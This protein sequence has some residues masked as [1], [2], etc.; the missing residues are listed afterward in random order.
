MAKEQ[1]IKKLAVSFSGGRTS[2][3]MTKRIVEEWSADFDE[4]VVAFMN[5]GCEH[6]A[7][8]EFVDKCDR[9]FGLGVVWIE[10]VVPKAKGEGIRHRLVDFSTA[11][12]DGEPFEAAVAKFGIYNSTSPKCTADLKI[13]PHDHYLKERGFKFGKRLDHFTAIGIRADE[14]DRINF[15]TRAKHGFIYPMAEEWDMTK[16]DVALEIKRWPFDLEIPGDHFGNCTWCWKKSLR[17]HMTLA[18]EEPE[19]F[20]FPRRMEEQFGDM[21]P[22]LK[23]SSDD[24]KARWFRG[25]RTVQDIID[26]ANR[27][28]FEPYKDDPYE[29]GKIPSLFDSVLDV[30]AACGDGCEMGADD[31]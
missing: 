9:T 23:K 10:A 31:D 15:R 14:M 24:G 3:V 2:A 13:R 5:T 26:L 4:I 6:E 17:K 8:L 29:H 7:T 18:L 16:R 22:H 19:V 20:N 25:H 27:G 21:T 28:G 12:R 1:G 30:G 11:S